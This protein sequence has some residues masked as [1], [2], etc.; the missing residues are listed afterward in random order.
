MRFSNSF[1]E[2]M[3]VLKNVK[4]PQLTNEQLCALDICDEW[5]TVVDGHPPGPVAVGG[6]ERAHPPGARGPHG[7]VDDQVEVLAAQVVRH[8]HHLARHLVDLDLIPNVG[9]HPLDW[10]GIH[11]SIVGLL[12]QG[13][14]LELHVCVQC[15]H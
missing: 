7:Q 10:L 8:A 2:I 11:G 14:P 1:M 6:H 9:K 5:H 15:V 3:G 12:L 13:R 4:K